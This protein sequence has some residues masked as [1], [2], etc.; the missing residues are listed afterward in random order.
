MK[1]QLGAFDKS[2]DNWINTDITPHMWVGRI[3]MLPRAMRWAGM[4]SKERFEQHRQGTFRRLK[5]VDLTKRL[6]FESDSV[7]AFFSS[8][9][10][11]HLFLDEVDRLV[12]EMHRCL[13]PGGICRVAVPD[14]EAT[15]KKF[16]S[17]D[18][19]QFIHEIFEISARSQVKN[20]HHSGFTQPF[21]K[22]LFLSAGFRTTSARSYREGQCPDLE[23]LDN[24]PVGSIF[25]EAVK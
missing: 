24:R 25:F 17:N 7:D 16:D 13:K 19:R 21:L 4:L 14:L 10:M 9:V 3:P 2:I 1:V 23:L 12:A 22:K 20:S 11:E 8:H 5:Y 6:P 15:V 18:P